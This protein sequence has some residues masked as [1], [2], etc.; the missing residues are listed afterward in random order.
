MVV[1]TQLISLKNRSVHLENVHRVLIY[2]L[3]VCKLWK[4]RDMTVFGDFHP[5]LIMYLDIS[6]HVHFF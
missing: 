3:F 6:F 1:S 5:V 4:A 2:S